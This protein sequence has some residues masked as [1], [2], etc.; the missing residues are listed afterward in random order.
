M[1]RGGQTPRKAI[2][3]LWSQGSKQEAQ[4]VPRRG[5][6]S[7][8]TLRGASPP[9]VSQD[10]GSERCSSPCCLTRCSRVILAKI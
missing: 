9:A 2:R 1:L 4:R 7:R 6:Q 10:D 8:A 5:P 3:R